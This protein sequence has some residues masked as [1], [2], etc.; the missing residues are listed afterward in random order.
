MNFVKASQLYWR[1]RIMDRDNAA[2]RGGHGSLI[3]S[4]RTRLFLT[5]ELLPALCAAGRKGA[6]PK[7]STLRPPSCGRGPQPRWFPRRS[8]P[9][10]MKFCWTSVPA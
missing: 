5:D 2:E 7:A 6:V 4:N 8:V 9:A 3:L 10:S 1:A